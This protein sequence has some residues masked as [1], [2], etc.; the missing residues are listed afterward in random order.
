M[1]TTNACSSGRISH[2]IDAAEAIKRATQQNEKT[3]VLNIKWQVANAFIAIFRAEK[4]LEVAISH[5]LSL[6]AHAKD[7]QTLLFCGMAAMPC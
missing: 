6:K 7:V 5:V 2:N 1:A 4:A 3:T